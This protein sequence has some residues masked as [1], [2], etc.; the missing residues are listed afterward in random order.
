[1][2]LS[3]Y[4]PLVHWIKRLS[5]FTQKASS[6]TW[7]TASIKRRK[8]GQKEGPKH[9]SSAKTHPFKLQQP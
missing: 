5:M 7:K 1:M 9:D 2:I 6:A 8:Q 3:E 4:P